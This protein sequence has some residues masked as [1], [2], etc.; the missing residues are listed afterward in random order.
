MNNLSIKFDEAKKNHDLMKIKKQ[1]LLEK[2]KL[3]DKISIYSYISEEVEL[4]LCQKELDFSKIE[5]DYYIFHDKNDKN[6]FEIECLYRKCSEEI[7]E[8]IVYNIYVLIPKNPENETLCLSVKRSSSSYIRVDDKIGNSFLKIPNLFYEI[9]VS[10]GINEYDFN[11]NLNCLEQ[12]SNYQKI[13]LSIDEKEY[14]IFVKDYIKNIYFRKTF[15]FE[16]NEKDNH[17][18]NESSE[19]IKTLL[20]EIQKEKND[21]LNHIGE[22]IEIKNTSITYKVEKRKTKLSANIKDFKEK[23]VGYTLIRVEYLDIEY[24]YIKDGFIKIGS[25]SL[26]EPRSFEDELINFFEKDFVLRKDF[27]R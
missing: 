7:S 4:L 19:E 27:L 22:V 21:L 2:I 25:F 16:I 14:E 17:I 20:N 11:K 13:K 15:L 18:E 6:F 26:I 9:N 3:T 10:I 5:K 12:F 23:N 1:E 8:I 24:C